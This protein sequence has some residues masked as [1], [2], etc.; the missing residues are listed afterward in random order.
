MATKVPSICRNCLAFCPI[1]VTVEDG[2]AVRVEG[3]RESSL[4]EGYTCPKGRALPHQH[5]DP[6][7]LLQC[8]ARGK[9]GKLHPV[10]SREL[11]DAIAERI[12]ALV[13]K[14][15]PRSVAAYIGTGVVAH[16]T[17]AVMAAAWFR[18]LGSPMLF[19]AATID[20]PAANVAAA[21]H[22]NWVAGAQ[23]FASSDTWMIVGANPVISKSNGA[24][25][26]N[27]G[28]RLKEAVQ[29]GMKI[30]V[31]D[32]RRTETA[33]R[34]HLHLQPVPS[35]DPVILAAMIRVIMAEELQDADFV[36]RHAQGMEALRQAVEP[37][38]PEVAG[39][40]AGLAPADI[41]AAAR[42]FANGKRGCVVCS[43]GP[44]FSTRS[45]LTFYLALCL[46][47]LCGRWGREGDVA[48]YGNTML[49][50]FTPK[51]QPYPPYPVF[52]ANALR[53][54]GLRENASGLPAAAL[55]DEILTEGPGQIR[56]LFCLGGN[57]MAAWP[58]QA[59]TAAAL[60]KLDLL[61]VTETRITE[62]AALADF[63]IASPMTLEI[64]A[65]TYFVEW[66]KYIGV[67]RGYDVPWAQYTSA[68][69]TPPPGSD[70]MD[71]RELFFRL[72]QRMGL[73]LRWIDRFGYGP[74]IEAPPVD[75]LLDMQRQPS[76]DEL[77]ALGCD[78]GRVPLDEIKRHPHGR[79]FEE[80]QVRIEPADPHCMDRLELG[81]PMMMQELVSIASDSSDRHPRP[82]LPFR[83]VSRRENNFMNSMGQ[84]DPALNS[85]RVDNPVH[86]NPQDLAALG[87]CER[88]LLV[89]R[90]AVG[91]VIA[92]AYADD[93]L[94]PGVVSLAQ[95]YARPAD[96]NRKRAT[97]SVTRLVDLDE[98]D[99]VTGIPRM[100]AIPVSLEI[101]R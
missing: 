26:Y 9:D 68:I 42:T 98:C 47:T 80:A 6:E 64:P 96:A 56:A 67:G 15:G 37:F 46:N 34:A 63:V 25:Y 81:A 3:D 87:A 91:R 1:L 38:T 22:G 101:F 40:R 70:V 16:P 57:P 11:I 84:Q 7:R 90:S 19:S 88:E 55:A 69:V 50:A 53:V 73:Q 66:L 32:P 39:A 20:K 23:S 51:A 65:A 86:V 4:Y 82:D 48:A 44:S 43:T 99:P 2:R 31:I 77:I 89:V 30:I 76:V 74:H 95:G 10:S 62:T 85:G 60:E 79:L 75:E 59:R 92:S 54:R 52:G 100:S 45:N 8:L 18:A 78:R 14:H 94:R 29:R 28:R 58:D 33:K 49:P 41:V 35:E 24:P 36:S 17:G 13:D 72:G 61:V 27:P 5:N 93:T 71:E 97:A 12:R 21:L 83:L